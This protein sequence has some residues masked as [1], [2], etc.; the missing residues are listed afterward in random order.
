MRTCNE[1]KRKEHDNDANGVALDT[2]LFT[3]LCN[4]RNCIILLF[5]VKDYMPKIGCMLQNSHSFLG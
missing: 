2:Y 5:S 1:Y 4:D 3:K